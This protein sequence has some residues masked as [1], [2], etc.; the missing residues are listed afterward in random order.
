M[1]TIV[2]IKDLDALGPMG[3]KGLPVSQVLPPLAELSRMGALF[4]LDTHAGTAVAPVTAAPTT[5][6]QWGLLNFSQNKRMYVLEAA[7]TIKS[8]TAGLGLALMMAT[9]IGPQTV[10]ASDYAS[11]VKSALDGSGTKPDVIITDNPTLVGGTPAWHVI[12]NTKLNEVATDSVGGG[13]TA[14]VG[15]AFSAP[16]N[17]G[18]VAMEVVGETGTTALFSVSFLI[19]ML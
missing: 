9:A 3:L 11:S 18:M 19:A 1:S 7:A 10:D 2:Q 14:N 16:G 12:A 4:A 5:S 6:P 13:L 17:W 15:G 8:G